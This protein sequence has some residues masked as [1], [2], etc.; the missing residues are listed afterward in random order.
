[1]TPGLPEVARG[2][3]GSL[4]SRVPPTD[5]SGAPIRNVMAEPLPLPSRGPGV[6]PAQG[7]SWGCGVRAGPVGML[8]VSP[9]G[10]RKAGWS[11]VGEQHQSGSSGAQ[12]LGGSASWPTCLYFGVGGLSGAAASVAGGVLR[13]PSAPQGIR[14]P[15]TDA[16]GRS[17]L[18]QIGRAGSEAQPAVG[19]SLRQSGWWQGVQQPGVAGW[20]VAS[21]DQARRRPSGYPGVR[22]RAG[23]G[24]Q[25]GVW[26]LDHAG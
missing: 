23:R 12:G 15:A 19:R 3:Q 2:P 9:G 25:V 20:A 14:E 18:C 13:P 22:P 4:S 24:T 11:L 7:G 21:G 6:N 16:E 17:P 8:G 26:P 5:G 1:M 10:K